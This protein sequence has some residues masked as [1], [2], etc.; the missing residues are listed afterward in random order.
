MSLA[1]LKYPKKSHRKPIKIPKDS[2]ELAEL[3]GIV[4][5]DGGINNKWQLVISLNS[6]LDKEY[7]QYI[8]SLI[9]KLFNISA[10]IRKRP[11]QNTLVVVASS[12]SLV[13]FLVSKGAAR[14]NKLN[15]STCS[16]LLRSLLSENCK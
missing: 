11:N 3:L 5:G 16:S 7:S 15:L 2:E 10:I 9:K 4:F 13:E 12:I 1:H 14:G 6:N 8:F